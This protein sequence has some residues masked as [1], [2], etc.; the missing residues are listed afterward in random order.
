MHQPAHD[1]F[2]EIPVTEQDIFDYVLA[3]APQFMSAQF[4]YESYVNGWSVAD[5]VRAAKLRRELDD[6]K[7]R[8]MPWHG[9]RL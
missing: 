2:G 7:I 6:I 5:K 9:Q 4:R 1:L 8:P 3:M